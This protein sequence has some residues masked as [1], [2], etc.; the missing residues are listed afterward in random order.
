MLHAAQLGRR[1]PWF[2]ERGVA[3]L[4]VGPG[5]TA[6]AGKIARW[7]KL[8]FPVLSDPELAAYRAFGLGRVMGVIQKSGVVLVDRD[9]LVRYRRVRGNPQAALSLTLLEGA[10]EAIR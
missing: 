1:F 9:G 10:V 5:G 7:L 2:E 4:A 6:M 3:L 8:P